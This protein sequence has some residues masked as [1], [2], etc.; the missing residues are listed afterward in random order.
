M[1]CS[2]QAGG[3]MSQQRKMSGSKKTSRYVNR[4]KNYR[5]VKGH[6]MPNH[7]NTCS[8]RFTKKLGMA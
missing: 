2:K 4:I 8:S 1:D 7:N 6:G 3:V 5:K